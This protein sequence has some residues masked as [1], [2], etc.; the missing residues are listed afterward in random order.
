MARTCPSCR[1]S[2]ND[3]AA[4]FCPACGQRLALT[5]DLAARED[6]PIAPPPRAPAPEVPVLGLGDLATEAVLVGVAGGVVG[7]IPC[8]N[9]LNCCCF[10]PA[11]ATVWVGL[12]VAIGR[13][14]ERFS[15]RAVLLAG[16]VAGVIAGAGAA[17][18][19][20]LVSLVMTDQADVKQ[21]Q[22]VVEQV[23]NVPPALREV[24]GDWDKLSL[25]GL[26]VNVPLYAASCA[27]VG[28]LG[29]WGAARTMLADKVVDDR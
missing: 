16:L 24:L 20:Y 1:A 5:S 28:V 6:A 27:V 26:L 2:V 29:A 11:F 3:D 9:V 18:G 15:F 13:R 25:L 12:G 7:S 22:Q 10:L 19:S 23:P 8:L 14:P 4:A 17:V 21:L